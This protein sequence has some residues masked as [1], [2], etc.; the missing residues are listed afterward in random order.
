[1]VTKYST[2]DEDEKFKVW[3]AKSGGFYLNQRGKDKVMLHK[4][5]CWHHGSGSGFKSTTHVKWTAER[6]EDLESYAKK[7]DFQLERCQDCKI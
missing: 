7:Q 1:M 6:F 3:N 5:G 2:K 4:A